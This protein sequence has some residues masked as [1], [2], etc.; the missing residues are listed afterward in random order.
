MLRG[1][2]YYLELFGIGQG[3][4]ER[5]R[6]FYLN[7]G[8]KLVCN[9]GSNVASVKETLSFSVICAVEGRFASLMLSILRRLQT[10]IC[11]LYV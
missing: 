10:Y 1:M 11:V 7:Y 9:F 3:K 5:F 4:K 6:R 2:A 8:Q